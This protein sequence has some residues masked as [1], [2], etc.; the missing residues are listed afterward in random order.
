VKRRSLL[1]LVG[2]LGALTAPVSAHEKGVIHLASKEVRAGG[3]LRLRGEKLPKS[4]TLRLEL[5]GTLETFPV[6][7]V[8]TDAAGRFQARLALP[9]EARA[10]GYTLVAL[11]PDGDVAARAELAIVAAAPAHATDHATMDSMPPTTESPHPTAE[12]MK[13]AVATTGGEWAVI[14]TVIAASLGGA[15]ALLRGAPRRRV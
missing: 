9:P 6:A 15:L 7:E 8:H 10:G 3:E 13:V 1:W 5:R 4:A 12:M 11:A 2:V 14:L